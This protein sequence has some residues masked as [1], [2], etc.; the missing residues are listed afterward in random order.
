MVLDLRVFKC[1]GDNLHVFSLKAPVVSGLVSTWAPAIQLFC[2]LPLGPEVLCVY[3]Y[4]C[5][6]GGFVSASMSAC[7]SQFFTADI[8]ACHNKK[9]I[10]VI[11]YINNG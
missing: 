1:Y 6:W 2:T 11:N 8:L 3:V 9:S 7:L 5:V 4:L 10:S